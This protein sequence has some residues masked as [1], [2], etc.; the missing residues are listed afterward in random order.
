MFCGNVHCQHGDQQNQIFK[1]SP[2]SLLQLCVV[3][4]KLFFS[5]TRCSGG[6]GGGDG[7]VV[8]VVVA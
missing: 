4:H 6:G 2:Q 3:N 1:F 7:V 5:R 8:V